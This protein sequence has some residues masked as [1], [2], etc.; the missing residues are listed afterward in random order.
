M[1]RSIPK[2]ASV[3]YPAKIVEPR[4][5]SIA[6]IFSAIQGEGTLVG[7]RHLFIRMAGCPFRCHYCDTPEALV[8][9]DFCRVET[10][11]ASRKFRSQPNPVSPESLNGIVSGFM[12]AEGAV[13]R[14]IAI[15]GGE[16][17]VQAGYLQEALPRRRA[18][19][20]KIYLE[21]AGAHV[22]EL[23]S[24]LEHVDIIAMDIK[25]PSATGMKPLWTA[26]RDFLKVALAKHVIVKVVV[27]RKTLMSEIEQIRDMIAEVDRTL[28]VVL[29]PVTP[30]WKIKSPPSIDHLL[31]WQLTLAAKL[32]NVR[33]IP[34]CHRALEDR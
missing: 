27:T 21:T 1:A 15:T 14:A 4:P 18:F 29:Q 23:K 5:G 28:P 25:P 17:L 9:A 16:P 19:G 31:M 12:A 11:P 26:H 2:P 32:E 20:K 8:P 34:Q 3:S 7:E 10:P 13:Y 6:G 33:V 24:V 22:A 30:A